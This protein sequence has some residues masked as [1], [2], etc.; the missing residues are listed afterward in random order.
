M[1]VL[2]LPEDP[3]YSVL[4]RSINASTNGVANIAK[5]LVSGTDEV[6]EMYLP[7]IVL[8]SNVLFK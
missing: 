3:D 6:S 5:V 2:E 7:M 4:K 8:L 1:Q